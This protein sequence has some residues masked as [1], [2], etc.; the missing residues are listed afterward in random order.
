VTRISGFRAG[1]I[2]EPDATH[3]GAGG[4]LP[5]IGGVGDDTLRGD[6]GRDELWG[7]AGDDRLAGEAGADTLWGGD[8]EDMLLGGRGDDMLEGGPGADA[9]VFRSGTEGADTIADWG[10]GDDRIELGALL[11]RLGLGAGDVLLDDAAVP[12]ATILSIA[13]TGV[14]VTIL[15]TRAEDFDLSALAATGVVHAASGRGAASAPPPVVLEQVPAYALYHG[16]GPTSVASVLGYWDLRGLSG[17]LDAEGWEAMRLTANVRDLISSPEH[18]A[19]FGPTP[20]DPDLPVPPETSIA[21]FLNTSEGR[22]GTGWTLLSAME[23]GIEAYAA[24]RGH[25]LDA[26]SV[27]FADLGW[28]EVVR[29]IDAGRPMI[30]LVDTE[31]DG[32]TGHFAPVLGYQ[33]RGEAGGRWF[34]AYT[35]WTE[36]ERVEWFEYRPMTVGEAWGVGY[37]TF[38]Q[39]V[40]GGSDAVFA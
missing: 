36:E 21:D 25:A 19:K 27:R 26:W 16:C 6:R 40:P 38:V 1:A 17:L 13:G 24:M 33:D 28:E 23:P 10:D 15:G 5:V 30:F 12:D 14:S 22:L 32:V 9:F 35:T 3:D 31:G 37:V 4:A 34:G 7:G 29:E 20:D 2:I 18:N 11:R 39:P 8:G